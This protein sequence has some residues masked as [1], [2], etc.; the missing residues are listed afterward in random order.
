MRYPR[1][2][3]DFS[4]IS[5]AII[6]ESFHVSIGANHRGQVRA[7]RSLNS[8]SIKHAAHM[9][10]SDSNLLSLIA[11]FPVSASLKE[12]DTGKY[13]INNVHN[14][15]EFGV[16]EGRDVTGLRIQDIS[17][18][19]TEWGR[20]FAGLVEMLDIVAQETKSPTIRRSPFV[21]VCGNVQ[22]GEITKL[23]IF[24]FNGKVLGIVTY[25]HDVTRTIPPIHVYRIYRYFH[26]IVDA[27]NR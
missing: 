3:V 16:R 9:T 10:K 19:T 13:V 24:G 17:F 14:L 12:A 4:S 25:R 20:H 7:G 15:R 23:P 11:N 21:D 8:R 6:C 22:M 18:P 26:P 5:R 27:I 2:G 1:Y